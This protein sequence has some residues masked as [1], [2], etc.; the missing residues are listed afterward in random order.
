MAYRIFSKNKWTKIPDAYPVWE[1]NKTELYIRPLLTGQYDV[2]RES[3]RA[4]IEH[5]FPNKTKAMKYAK[6]WM[7]RH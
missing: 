6:S 7:R 1:K 2:I 5:T 4:V 3:P